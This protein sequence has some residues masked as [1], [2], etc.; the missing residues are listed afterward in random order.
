MSPRGR[1]LRRWLIEGL[2]VIVPLGVT[3][4]ILYWIFRRLDLLLGVYLYRELGY[5][6]PGLGLLLLVV[7][8]VVV[9]WVAERTV[10]SRMAGWWRGALERLPVVRRLYGASHRIVRTIFGGDRRFF[11][12][13]VLFEYPS[14]G[15]WALGF[16]TAATPSAL[17]AH[18]P[19]AVTIFLPTAP[20]PASG[21]L[22]ILPRQRVIRLP[23]TVEEGF[24]FVLSAGAVPPQAR[25]QPHV[26]PPEEPAP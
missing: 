13:V 3:A 25:A 15:R 11:R 14:E 22:V 24:T 8:L 21:F 20:N 10:G 19:D 17:D 4:Y 23:I 7:L 16:V 18:V 5:E 26:V 1:S 6:V 9:G 12:E 2:I